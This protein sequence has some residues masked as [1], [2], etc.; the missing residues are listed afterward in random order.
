MARDMKSDVEL[1][2]DEVRRALLEAVLSNEPLTIVKAPPGSGKTRLTLDAAALLLDEKARVA[3]V[4]QTNSQADDICRRFVE[5]FGAN[6]VRFHSGTGLRPSGLPDG[7]QLVSKSAW[8][9]TGPIVAVGTSAKWGLTGIP[10]ARFDWLLVDEAWQLSYAD[11]ML[12]QKVAPRFVMVGDPGQILPVV[13]IDA[14]RWEVA[15]TPPHRP[16]PQILIEQHEQTQ[17]RVLELPATWRLPP[18]SA[19]VVNEFYDFKFESAVG[20]GERSFS[21]G[22]REGKSEYDPVIEMLESGSMVGVTL[23]TPEGGP[24]LEEDREVA[25]AAAELVRRILSSDVTLRID[26]EDRALEAADIGMVAT[27]RVMNTRMREALPP[28]VA[29]EIMVDTTERWQG[30]QRPIMIAIHPVSGVTDPGVFDL[31][32]QRLCVMASRHQIGLIIV[33][34]DHLPR[35]LHELTPSATQHPGRPDA[36]GDGREKHEQFWGDLERAGRVV[37]L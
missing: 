17:P 35:T 25:V 31:E 3:I 33:T 2:I 1:R 8:L 6:V 11:F 4:A 28:P 5:D 24:P 18:D 23:P 10:A 13:S 37:A 12:M 9:P 32:T 16:A 15:D 14:S 29:S 36:S 19:L 20:P 7:V 22:Q 30:L 34:R 26:G 21:I 27:H